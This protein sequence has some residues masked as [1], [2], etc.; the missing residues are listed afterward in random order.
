MYQLNGSKDVITVQ[1]SSSK[2]CINCIVS[3]V[4]GTQQLSGWKDLRNVPTMQG[5]IPREA[6][7]RRIPI[8]WGCGLRNVPSARGRDRG[9]YQLRRGGPSLLLP[10]AGCAWARVAVAPLRLLCC[11]VLCGGLC[12]SQSLLTRGPGRKIAEHSTEFR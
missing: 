10:S 12:R 5:S 4:R 9:T 3:R 11:A 6:G 8:R 7:L 1:I 2:G